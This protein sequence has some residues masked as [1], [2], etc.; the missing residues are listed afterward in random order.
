MARNA[1]KHQAELEA[2]GKRGEAAKQA[3][4]TA[5]LMAIADT[6]NRIMMAG[7]TSNQ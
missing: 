6:L 4:N 7:C 1:Q 3:G 5:G 2:L